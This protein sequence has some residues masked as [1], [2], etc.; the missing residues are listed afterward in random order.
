[1][2]YTIGSQPIYDESLA[3]GAPITCKEGKTLFKTIA[4]AK[5]AIRA[6]FATENG[7]VLW[8]AIYEVGVLGELLWRVWPPQRRD[9]M[10]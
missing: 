5:K 6:G 2:R 7:R 9:L 3:V 4:A 8:P 10:P 1:M